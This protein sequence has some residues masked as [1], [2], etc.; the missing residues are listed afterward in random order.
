MNNL[1]FLPGIFLTAEPLNFNL[2]SNDGI[3]YGLTKIF[4]VIPRISLD[5]NP[6]LILF[7]LS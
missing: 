4:K 6:L 2:Y 3:M 5:I 1:F 7:S